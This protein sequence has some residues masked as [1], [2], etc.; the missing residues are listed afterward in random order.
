[1]FAVVYIPDFALQAVLRH[2][3][4]LLKAQVALVNDATAKSCVSQVTSAARACG[5]C[6][7][8]TSTQAKARCNGMAFRVRSLSQEAS[9]QEVLLEC[10]YLSAAYIESTE[11]GVC[12]MDLRGLPM[13]KT[14]SL[15]GAL[16]R[17]AEELRERLSQFGLISRIGIASAPGLAWQAAQTEAPLC[18]VGNAPQFW[19][20]LPIQNLTALSELSI[21]LSKWGINTV[22]DFL[23]LG[24]GRIAERLG[25]AGVELFERAKADKIRPLRLVS[26]RRRYEEFFQFEHWVETLEPLLFSVRRLLEQLSKR[27][28]LASRSI[29]EI[30]L[31]L[32]LDSG[33]AHEST[34][35]IAAPTTDSNA[36]FR[37]CYNH[38]ET[39]RT[40]SPVIALALRAHTCEITVQ[41]FQLFETAVRDPSR[42]YETVGRLNALLGADR[43]GTPVLQDSH[44]PDDFALTQPSLGERGAP[45][46]TE[47]P[48]TPRKRGMPLR[49][50]RPPLSASVRLKE[51]APVFLNSS[52]PRGSIVK[53][54][55]PWRDSGNWWQS[56]W[57]REE[58]DIQTKDGAL[59]RI[60]LENNQWCVEGAYD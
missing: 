34:I 28:G 33:Q 42:F 29:A 21:V 39:V 26:P 10:A 36:L 4:D 60:F 11:A 35:K 37:I 59:Y 9:A 49:R 30:T 27:V 47:F 7:G 51:G 17:W 57:A 50:F 2:E 56:L 16:E 46:E 25:A 23:A 3:P 52:G 18:Y 12:T 48:R 41:Q 15:A 22:S 44:R 13:L 53:S 45:Q 6:A 19:E 43:V 20:K 24:K 32:E 1:V 38:L 5:V 40:A 58:W 54:Q 8:M 31:R 55:G 14:H